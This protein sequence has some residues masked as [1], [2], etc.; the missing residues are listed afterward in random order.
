MILIWRKG[1]IPF[2]LIFPDF[3]HAVLDPPSYVFQTVL[4]VVGPQSDTII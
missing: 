4:T 3:L 1:F 2:T